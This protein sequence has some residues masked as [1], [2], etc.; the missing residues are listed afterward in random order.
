M[1]KKIREGKVG[2]IISTNYG[3]NYAKSMNVTNEKIA[4]MDK[5]LVEFLISDVDRLSKHDFLALLKKKGI[6]S[7]GLFDYK[8]LNVE[9]VTAGEFFYIEEFEGRER[10]VLQNEFYKA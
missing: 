6:E 9:W 5:Q 1:E 3:V 8:S 4:R 7:D 2:V 10:V